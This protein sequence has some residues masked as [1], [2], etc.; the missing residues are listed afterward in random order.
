[1]TPAS[2]IPVAPVVTSIMQA[3]SKA[4]ISVSANSGANPKSAILLSAPKSADYA[5]QSFE[6]AAS[7]L[8]DTHRLATRLSMYL[9][10]AKSVGHSVS[11]KVNE[12]I[13]TLHDVTNSLSRKYHYKASKLPSNDYIDSIGNNHS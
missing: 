9:P 12:I 8:T 4:A 11:A 7:K 1:M 10:V 5:N 2:V 13:S 6:I 3:V